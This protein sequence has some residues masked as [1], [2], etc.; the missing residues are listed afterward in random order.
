MIKAHAEPAGPASQAAVKLLPVAASGA[1]TSIIPP[2]RSRRARF[3]G[4]HKI[5]AGRGFGAQAPIIPHAEGVGP[6]SRAAINC[7][8]SRLR[9]AGSYHS[10]APKPVG[11]ASRAGGRKKPAQR[12]ALRAVKAR[13][14]SQPAFGSRR[15]CS[16][17]QRASLHYP[18]PGRPPAAPPRSPDPQNRRDPPDQYG[19]HHTVARCL[20]LL[21]RRVDGSVPSSCPGRSPPATG[22]P[23]PGHH[24]QLVI[25]KR[26]KGRRILC[27]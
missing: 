27:T 7:C 24:R 14:F 18:L 17:L 11:P 3:A 12:S 23:A 5:A 15:R 4:S 13:Y 26:A 16:L 19:K 21:S 10:P 1:Q 20:L 22:K 25:R 8:R 6:A 2:R 9:G